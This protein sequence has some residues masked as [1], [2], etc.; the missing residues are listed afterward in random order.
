MANLPKVA[1]VHG[2]LGHG[3]S[4]A[5]VMWGMEALKHDF[6]VSVVTAG[7]VD[8]PE[9]NRFY[10]TNLTSDDFIVRSIKMPAT[11]SHLRAG[12]AIRGAFFA[13]AV[14]SIVAEYDVLISAYG[15]SDF[16]VP[17]IQYVQDFHWD[18][19]LRRQFD[20]PP[21][22]TRS[23]FHKYRWLRRLYLRLCSSVSYSSGRN[24]FSGDD[25]MV[26]VSQ[27]IGARLYDRRG[28][29]ASVL[30]PA[31][32]GTFVDVP[33]QSRRND[34]VC[35]GRISPQKR[36]ERMIR[37]IEKVRSRGHDVRLRIIGPLDHSPYSRTIAS[38]ARR[39]P[40]WAL[41]EG[42]RAADEKAQ[43]MAECRYGLHGREG[44]AFG[45]A[46]A[47]MVKAGCVT[48]AP[49]EGGQAEIVDHQALLYRDDDD[50]VEKIIAV[51]KNDSLRAD[52]SHH[53]RR[54]AE[55]FSA[56]DFMVGLRE[57]VESFLSASRGKATRPGSPA[58]SGHRA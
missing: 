58:A 33:H 14:H 23:W 50:A 54:Q 45:I 9:L 5:A 48:F 41:L 24:V 44:E 21:N 56:E 28:A 22:G 20:P 29:F 4:E 1:I 43:I 11:L 15:P 3:G 35:I 55:K 17:A 13:R 57:T 30:Y 19:T 12:D 37:I 53:L 47:E 49:V 6:S 18:E 16:G 32:I 10:G 31:V 38:L 25:V 7:E 46:V 34:F 39:Y 8:L 2:R 40:E 52:L 42:R 26:A 51:L 36:I 27:W